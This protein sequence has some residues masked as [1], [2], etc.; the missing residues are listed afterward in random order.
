MSSVQLCLFLSV[1]FFCGRLSHLTYSE[2]ASQQSIIFFCTL[3]QFISKSQYSIHCHC[4]VDSVRV[5]G[6]KYEEFTVLLALGHT[7]SLTAVYSVSFNNKPLNGGG[8]FFP[9]FRNVSLKTYRSLFRKLGEKGGTASTNLA[10]FNRKRL[11]KG[12]RIG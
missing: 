8:K 10:T 11:G 9:S 7:V 12:E 1:F 3:A 4:T 6:S 5:S 2:E